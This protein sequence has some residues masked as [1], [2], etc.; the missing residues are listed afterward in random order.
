[1]DLVRFLAVEP[2]SSARD[3]ADYAATYAHTLSDL[4]LREIA[5]P[6]QAIDFVDQCDLQHV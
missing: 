5:L 2:S 4:A 3:R 1:M 6:K